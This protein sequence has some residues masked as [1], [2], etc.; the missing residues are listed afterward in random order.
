M[1]PTTRLSWLFLVLTFAA[2][3]SPRPA[4]PP[5]ERQEEP[6]VCV[7]FLA[8]L[9][10]E[11]NALAPQVV[12]EDPVRSRIF[13]VCANSSAVAVIEGAAGRV[14]AL[15][16]GVRMPRSLRR[17]GVAVSVHTGRC[18]ICGRRSLVVVDP[19]ARSTWTVPL[20]GAFESVA[21]DEDRGLVLLAGRTQGKLAVVD[22]ERRTVRLVAFG[23]AFP[24]L[25]Y[26]AASA[27]PPIRRVFT[28]PVTGRAY[29]LDGCTATLVTVDV[30]GG[31][32]TASRKLPLKAVPRW[33]A[34]GYDP[35]HGRIYVL[36]EDDH[37]CA[38]TAAAL[39][40]RGDADVVVPIPKGFREPAGVNCDPGRG[41]LYVPYDNNKAIHVVTFE[42]GGKVETVDLPALGVDATA[43]LSERRILYA[44][45]WNQA[46]L[47][48]VDVKERKLSRLVPFFPVYPHMNHMALDSKTGRLYVPTG[49]AAVNGTFGAAVTVF[50]PATY[51]FSKVRTGWAPTALVPKP[52]S[53]HFYVFDTEGGLAD[54]APDGSHTVHTL[55]WPYAREAIPSP[56]GAKVLV[57][58]GPHSSMWPNFYI[59]AT[60]DGIL[61]ID[62][63]GR[64]IADRLTPRLA[65]GIR[66]DKRGN[67]WMLQNT[68]GK[69]AP[70]LLCHPKNG[71]PWFDLRLLPATDNECVLR[72]L[73]LDPRSGLLCVVR[74][75][76]HTGERGRFYAV[77]PARRKVVFSLP[78]GRIP[79]GICLLPERHRAYV[80]EAAED[81]L[82]VVDLVQGTVR[83]EPVGS[84]P[85]AAASHPATGRVYV[86]NHEGRS[87][88]VIGPDRKKTSVPLPEGALPDNLVV[89]RTTGRVYVSAHGK[90]EF[91]LY[92][93]DPEKGA[94]HTL[95]STPHP[96]GETAFRT[97][98]AAFSL[99]GQWGDGIFRITHLM[100]DRRG[101]LWAA[102]Y[103]GGKLWIVRVRE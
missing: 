103:L 9:G 4:A 49:S 30:D 7:D 6:A 66:F 74:A 29:L 13:A 12:A 35:A 54:V 71:E 2:P 83:D 57:A 89:D 17:E 56:D 15:P 43:Y 25:P 40:T 82:S 44:A 36:L 21:V 5:G 55:P 100:L 65:Q 68:W 90:K 87:L 80:P 84:Y 70:P 50:D 45:S 26:M 14:Y 88:S 97:A 60:R 8:P 63:R 20:P 11:A 38:V 10:L 51:A 79:T 77:N 28:N 1:S 46:A 91:R 31:K 59:P 19:E 75:A 101:R 78:L 81:S 98:E 23:R 41:E 96:Y 34:A 42:G 16:V 69:E 58:Y 72:A 85:L 3:A 62:G 18:F 93:Y 61:E 102:D 47:Y 92:E 73:V 32:A 22:P 64:V 33:H 53:D 27:P 95:L 76:A 86:V 67:L 52:G 24:P 94:V 37:R 48:I 99:Q 39:D